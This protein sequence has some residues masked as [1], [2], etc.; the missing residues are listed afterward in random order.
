MKNAEEIDPCTLQTI[1]DSEEFFS[2]IKRVRFLK[3]NED[4]IY[5]C[6][7]CPRK[8]GTNRSKDLG[9]CATPLIRDKNG[10]WCVP[11]A[12]AALH[13]WEE[14][15][16]SGEN[17]SGAVFF[18]GCNLGCIFCQNREISTGN[19]GKGVSVSRLCEIFFELEAEG[20][21]N[22]NLV[23]AAHVLPVVREALIMAKTKGLRIPILYNTSSYETVE[24]LKTLDGLVDIYLPDLKYMSSALSSRYSFA[25]NYPE[26]AKAAIAEMVRQT[27][28]AVFDEHGLIAKGTIVRHLV[29]PGSSMDSKHVIHYLYETYGDEIYISIM[30]QYTPMPNVSAHSQLGKKV[31]DWEYKKIVDYAIN[32][33]VENG[34]VQDSSAS[35]SDFIPKFDYTGV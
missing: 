4:W 24:S 16:I 29:L 28:P 25:P 14:P 1:V 18:S 22:I 23:T 34:F 8:C 33:G 12:R 13:F 15:C 27:G 26:V 10:E 5:S 31:S 21:N 9:R 32:L 3:M 20:A 19:V 35:D 7:L 6:G 17:G 2:I 11:V 30:N